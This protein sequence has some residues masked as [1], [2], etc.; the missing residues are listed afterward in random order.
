MGQ[1]AWYTPAWRG[2][3]GPYTSTWLTG[4]GRLSKLPPLAGGFVKDAK[5]KTIKWLEDNDIGKG[6]IN[7][8]L[9]DWLISRQR[10]WGTPIP[11]IHCPA[12]GEVPVD[13]NDLP[14]EL[15]YDVDFSLGGESPLARNEKYINVNCPKCGAGCFEN[16]LKKQTRNP[17]FFQRL[18]ASLPR[19]AS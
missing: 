2:R 17:K 3:T 12:C 15:P 13:E 1:S 7:Y 8:R 11:I 14:V 10:Y 6:T 19:V 16:P 4:S 5:K 18:D 9:R